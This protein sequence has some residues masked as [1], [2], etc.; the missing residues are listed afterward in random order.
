MIILA[1][2]VALAAAQPAVQTPPASSAHS[3]A[4]THR[5]HHC[6]C[7]A[8]GGQDRDGC[9]EHMHHGAEQSG[10]QDH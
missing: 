1:T 4:M 7:C 6:C 3:E 2:A 9:A 10:H 8:D 5:G